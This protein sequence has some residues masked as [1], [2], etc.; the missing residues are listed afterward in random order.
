MG[1]KKFGVPGDEAVAGSASREWVLAT[2]E[3]L[4]REAAE[5]LAEHVPS[6]ESCSCGKPVAG[7]TGWADH[8]AGVLF[9]QAA[10]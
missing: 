8:A 7:A 5:R 1:F 2:A 9:P 3:L 10:Q 6:A 4:R